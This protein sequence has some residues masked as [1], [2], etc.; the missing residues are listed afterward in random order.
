NLRHPPRNVRCTS[1]HGPRPE[2][3]AVEVHL[4]VAGDREN[5]IGGLIADGGDRGGDHGDFESR[6]AHTFNGTDEIHVGNA[7]V[8]VTAIHYGEI[9]AI[10]TD[11]LGDHAQ[12][13]IFHFD[14]ILRV[15]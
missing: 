15:S 1:T 13:G 4:S 12:L 7:R 11:L 8:D 6:P 5:R 3:Q 9:H 2:A 10:V 14:Q